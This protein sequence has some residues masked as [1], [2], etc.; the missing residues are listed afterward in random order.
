MWAVSVK[1][2][3]EKLQTRI[4]ICQHKVNFVLLR[5]EDNNRQAEFEVLIANNQNNF[6]ALRYLF[7][8]LADHIGMPR[9]PEIGSLLSD[10]IRGRFAAT[11]T[12]RQEDS[13]AAITGMIDALVVFF[14]ESSHAFTCEPP[15]MIKPSTIQYLNLLK[16]VYLLEH[17]SRDPGFRVFREKPMS[18]AWW[19]Y[20]AD[21]VQTE[22]RRFLTGED[23]IQQVTDEELLRQNDEEFIVDLRHLQDPPRLDPISIN[24]GQEPL[25]E[26]TL[27]SGSATSA[28]QLYIH[29]LNLNR[30]RMTRTVAIPT[31]NHN[32]TTRYHEQELNVQTVSIDPIYAMSPQAQ[33]C[34]V[35]KSTSCDALTH[36]LHFTSVQDAKDFQMIITN[37]IVVSDQASLVSACKKVGFIDGSGKVFAGNGRI[38]LWSFRDPMRPDIYTTQPPSNRN[39]IVHSP[40]S[41]QSQSTLHSEATF[42]QRTLDGLTQMRVV[43][44]GEHGNDIEPPMPYQVVM[45]TSVGGKEQMISIRIDEDTFVN[46]DKCRC[47]KANSKC[48]EVFIDHRSKKLHVTTVTPCAANNFNARNLAVFGRVDHHNHHQDLRHAIEE[49][50]K[51]VVLTFRDTASKDH[52]AKR[53]HKAC[54]EMVKKHND[55][56]TTGN[57]VSGMH[58]F[59]QSG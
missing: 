27:V 23:G 21:K 8:Q 26:K 33:P 58:T 48:R 1:E 22:A 50:A 59:R 18:A 39:S 40:G 53:L 55:Y 12:P 32:A 25:M 5:Q 44:G 24:L 19:Q 11:Q 31:Q 6:D 43:R 28:E 4:H 45:M 51:Y 2:D 41:S 42:T 36:S 38:Q 14:E 29:R 54:V 16:C 10:S 35:W 56:T 3:V 52:F 57:N 13:N 30:L 34:V 37:Y 17:I 15:S 47:S 9:L 20:H 7:Q 46:P 49:Q